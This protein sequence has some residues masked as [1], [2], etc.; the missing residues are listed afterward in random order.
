M[1]T[2]SEPLWACCLMRPDRDEP[3]LLSEARPLKAHPANAVTR[4]RD[5]LAFA[6]AKQKLLFLPLLLCC[7][8]AN[9]LLPSFQVVPRL[10]GNPSGCRN[11]G[12]MPPW[13]Q[14]AERPESA[15]RCA[16]WRAAPPPACAPRR[17]P[18]AFCRACRL[19]PQASDPSGAARSRG[20]SAP[21]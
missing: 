16:T 11:R 19:L 1:R 7:Q 14:A 8:F 20:R 21:K 12:A 5:G 10:M 15:L 9:C 4:T 13:P 6:I 2:R 3:G 17:P 18:L